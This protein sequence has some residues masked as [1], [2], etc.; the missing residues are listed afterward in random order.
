MSMSKMIT[1]QRIQ[2]NMFNQIRAE[3]HEPNE[4]RKL[5]EECLF[6]LNQ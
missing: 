3:V 6:N 4:Y 5:L 2:E 1:K